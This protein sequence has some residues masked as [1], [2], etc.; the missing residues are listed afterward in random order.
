MRAFLGRFSAAMLVVV[1]ALVF[2]G[3]SPAV[4]LPQITGVLHGGGCGKPLQVKVLS[5]GGGLV[6]TRTLVNAKRG[7]ALEPH[8]VSLDEKRFIFSS[9]DCVSELHSL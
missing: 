6:A 3:Q 1:G 4:A 5:E 8:A 7:V 2:V 9:Y